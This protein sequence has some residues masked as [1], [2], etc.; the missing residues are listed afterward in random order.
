MHIPHN[1]SEINLMVHD[2]IMEQEPCELFPPPYS[3]D[4]EEAWKVAEKVKL[5]ESIII[6]KVRNSVAWI[7]YRKGI[8]Q[9][10]LFGE[11]ERREVDFLNMKEIAL[12][13]SFPETICR[14]SLVLK[15][16]SNERTKRSDQHSFG[17]FETTDS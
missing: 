8:E 13:Y 7:A 9:P 5:F 11:E 14:A 17:L 12:G 2:M 3:S 10:L 16:E 15:G 1:N 4:I 6:V